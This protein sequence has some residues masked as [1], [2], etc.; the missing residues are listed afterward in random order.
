MGMSKIH[1]SEPEVEIEIKKR[2]LKL[3]NLINRYRIFLLTFFILADFIV[4]HIAGK[5]LEN[6]F[7]FGIPVILVV[8]FFLYKLHLITKKDRPRPALKY[9]TI[10]IDYLIIFGGFFEVHESLQRLTSISLQQFLLVVTILFI[11]INSLAALK[12]Q[13]RAILFSA[14]LGMSLNVFIHVWFG[15]HWIIV[16]YTAAFILLSGI[17]NLYISRFIFQFIVTNFKLIVTMDQLK[18]ANEEIK[19]QNEEIK[20]Q[21]DELEVQNDYLSR[22]RDEITLQKKQI[23]SSI[24]YASIIQQAVLAN[25]AEI[26]E[27]M[28]NYFVVYKPR[29]IVSGDFYWFKKVDLK[30]T[31]YRIFTAVDCTGHGVPGAFMSML[32]TSFL[33]EIVNEKREKITAAAILNLLRSHVK[34][35]LHQE[36]GDR[37]ARDGMDTALCILDYKNMKLQ[38]AGANNPMFIIRRNGNLD[39]AQLEEFKADKM[40]I[41]IHIKERESFT[42]HEIDV[43]KGDLVYL[44]SDGYVD[45][46]GGEKGD[47]FKMKRF[48][49]LIL[50]IQN[51]PLNEQK[52]ALENNLSSW[53]GREYKQL[54]DITVIGVE[55]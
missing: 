24:E 13:K 9:F 4:L 1:R 50:S 17:F 18:D 37:L 47:K 5:S 34:E 49:E 40:P 11:T 33:N 8:Y 54:D 20:S 27:V 46:F 10:V 45:Q 25:D 28:S 2:E 14:A 7:I 39:Q 31:S 52:Q 43:K 15:S 38:Y 44:F 21:N 35:H 23:T 30:D 55:I 26:K 42:N 36:A 12:I 51:L 53:M 29:D 48:R 19:N 3:E 32:G 6:R 41:G 22:Q 16:F